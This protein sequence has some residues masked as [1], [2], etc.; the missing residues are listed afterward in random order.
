[1]T[2]NA[3][4][5]QNDYVSFIMKALLFEFFM[6]LK[7]VLANI[8][9]QRFSSETSKE[10]ILLYNVFT[11]CQANIFQVIKMDDFINQSS[12]LSDDGVF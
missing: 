2:R 6:V 3:D 4:I 12:Y 1:M 11:L 8:F 5:N 9:Q 10:S 7:R